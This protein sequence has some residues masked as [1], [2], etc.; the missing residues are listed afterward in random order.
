MGLYE[1]GYEEFGPVSRACTVCKKEI[2]KENRG[3]TG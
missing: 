3:E 2:E 1:G